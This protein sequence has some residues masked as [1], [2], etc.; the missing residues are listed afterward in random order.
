MSRSSS[1]N[2]NLFS[3]SRKR[4]KA[5]PRAL[6]TDTHWIL[7][8]YPSLGVR[9]ALTSWRPV[10]LSRERSLVVSS[11][12]ARAPGDAADQQTLSHTTTPLRWS[13]SL[14]HSTSKTR[15]FLLECRR[16]A[17]HEVS[18]CRPHKA[19]CTP[20]QWVWRRWDLTGGSNR[21]S[22]GTCRRRNAR[23]G[24]LF[25]CEAGSGANGGG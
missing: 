1:V 11:P 17:Q 13:I 14:V 15:A 5:T 22:N 6:C 7:V 10:C 23:T 24:A 21:G 3:T 16:V 9:R 19:G 4:R 25:E 12:R 18:R 2:A 20:C 8:S